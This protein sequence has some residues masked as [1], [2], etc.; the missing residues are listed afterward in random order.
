L[1]KI[2]LLIIC[3]FFLAIAQNVSAYDS[4]FYPLIVGNSQFYATENTYNSQIGA[5]S[6]EIV[7]TII[8]PVTAG[9]GGGIQCNITYICEKLFPLY[10]KGS[11]EFADVENVSNEIKYY[12]GCSITPTELYIYLNAYDKICKV[13]KLEKLGEKLFPK[14]PFLGIFMLLIILGLIIFF[15]T[16]QGKKWFVAW[17]RKKKK[18][19]V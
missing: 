9:G 12:T 14:Q 17:K 15:L 13:S 1:K 3:I 11:Y 2:I 16:R 8:T 6:G 5:V 18:K 19:K 4:Q 10:I 7:T